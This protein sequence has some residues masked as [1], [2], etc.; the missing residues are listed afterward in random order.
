MGEWKS[1][2]ITTGIASLA[3]I[4]ANT[5]SYANISAR[6]Q[7][8]RCKRAS[9][10]QHQLLLVNWQNISIPVFLQCPIQSH[11]NCFP[12]PSFPPP[13]HYQNAS[14]SQLDI[15]QK[16]SSAMS[17][18]L[19]PDDTTPNNHTGGKLGKLQQRCAVSRTCPKSGVAQEDML[20]K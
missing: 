15:G 4:K 17:L 8:E 3:A 13:V 20:I 2:S 18:L 11:L 7:I 12:C 14:S 19:F 6:H 1:S 5:N 9:S 10:V 16:Y